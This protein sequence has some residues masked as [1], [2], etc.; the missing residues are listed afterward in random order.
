MSSEDDIDLRK[1]SFKILKNKFSGF[2]NKSQN[3]AA[4]SL[5]SFLLA[6]AQPYIRNLD[7]FLQSA[8]LEP[9]HST[10]MNIGLEVYLHEGGLA[11]IGLFLFGFYSLTV[12]VILYLLEKSPINTS[13][14]DSNKKG[15]DV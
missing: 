2:F 8:L 4:L 9:S 14:T 5:G 6:G 12:F 1:D 3:W 10:Y 7:S 13:S 11:E 15:D